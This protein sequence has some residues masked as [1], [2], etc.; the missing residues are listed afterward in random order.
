MNRRQ[1][2]LHEKRKFKKLLY[3]VK[4]AYL[5]NKQNKIYQLAASSPK[6]F[7]SAVK[8][9]HNE[10]KHNKAKCV[11]PSV[12]RRHFEKL[13]N[14]P[15]TTKFSIPDVLEPNMILDQP[16]EEGEILE[17]LMS[18]LTNQARISFLM[19]C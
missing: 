11:P 18:K 10:T 9:L 19:I 17:Q 14:S 7:W 4:Q 5:A 3:H 15:K 8:K 6:I 12:W 16:F 13:L 2:Y 1:V